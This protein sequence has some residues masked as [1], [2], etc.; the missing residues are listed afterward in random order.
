MKVGVK[1]T[2]L[3]FQEQT[4]PWLSGFAVAMMSGLVAA[5]FNAE[6]TLPYYA[7]LCTVGIHLTHQVRN[8]RSDSELF[9][10]VQRKL[11][12][13]L[14]AN[15]S[16]HALITLLSFRFTHWTSAD[17]KTAGRNLSQTET[18]GCCCF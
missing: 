4:K 17:Q 13:N 2:A 1:S 16:Q 7:V 9:V 8:M 14:L 10:T 3:R 6:Q 15:M 5:G 12:L 11:L 18:L